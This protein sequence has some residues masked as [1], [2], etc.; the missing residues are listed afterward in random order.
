M[1]PPVI[2]TR[3]RLICY[4]TSIQTSIVVFDWKQGRGSMKHFKKQKSSCGFVSLFLQARAQVPHLWAWAFIIT[5]SPSG[6]KMSWDIEKQ[7]SNKFPLHYLNLLNNWVFFF[8]IIHWS[9]RWE[10]WE[11]LISSGFKRQDFIQHAVCS[12]ILLRR[13][14]KP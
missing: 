2:S 14:L 1:W 11:Q 9:V 8:F 12:S 7:R 10:L 6:C 4:Q 13:I 5:L 3:L